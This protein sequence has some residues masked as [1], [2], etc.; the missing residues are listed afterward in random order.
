MCYKESVCV[1][2]LGHVMLTFTVV[3]IW[4]EKGKLREEEDRE[5]YRKKAKEG[6]KD[7]ETERERQKGTERH[8]EIEI[9]R[10]TE[11][12]GELRLGV[13]AIMKVYV[14]LA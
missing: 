2:S 4:Q 12:E 7:R 1:P 6:D 8:R 14:F 3:E 10:W 5:A 11:R 9:G 13:C